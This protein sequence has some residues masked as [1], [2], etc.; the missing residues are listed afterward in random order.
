MSMNDMFGTALLT[1]YRSGSVDLYK[2]VKCNNRGAN[3][4]HFSIT[5]RDG[6]EETLFYIAPCSVTSQLL[7]SILLH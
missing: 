2:T 5:L 6:S 4:N 1:A 7:P 3:K